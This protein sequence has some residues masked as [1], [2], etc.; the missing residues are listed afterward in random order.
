MNPERERNESFAKFYLRYG[1]KE[2][3]CV[4]ENT[5]AYLY[6]NPEFDHLFYITEETDEYK[7]GFRIWR[8]MLGDRFDLVVKYMI[9]AG[10]AVESLEDID[11]CDLESYY[12]SYPDKIKLPIYEIG[13][14]LDRK[15]ANWGKFLQ[16]VEITIEDF[17]T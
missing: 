8:E 3:E 11:E 6:E 1:D 10:F 7:N 9:D 14:T 12:K 13:P 17:N 16:T 4:P 2:L 5:E 15:I